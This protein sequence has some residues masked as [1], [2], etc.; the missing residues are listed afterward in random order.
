LLEDFADQFKP[1]SSEEHEERL[2]T[3][4]DVDT[5]RGVAY[6][7]LSNVSKES[8]PELFDKWSTNSVIDVLYSNLV[9]ITEYLDSPDQL[10]EFIKDIREAAEK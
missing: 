7:A 1:I 10:R 8:V 9:D 6:N 5:L 3:T 2:R 4:T